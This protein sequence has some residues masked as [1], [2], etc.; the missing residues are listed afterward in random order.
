MLKELGKTPEADAAAAKW[1]KENPK[2]TMVRLYLADLE[3]RDK[4]YRGAAKLYKEV[5]ELQ[6]NNAVAMNN[7]AWVLNEMKDPAALPTAEKAL[8]LAPTSPAVADTLGWILYSRGD[9]KR[10]IDLMRK[11]SAAAPNAAEIRIHLAK[12]L[13]KTGETA[14]AK[15]ELEAVVAMAGGGGP[16]KD[17]AQA[18]LKG[19]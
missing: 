9:T 8:S 16:F 11:A 3:L 10:G 17:E 19:L 4:D 5:V 7:L 2:D 15:K 12:A 13:I 6:P 14:D 1:I 18:L